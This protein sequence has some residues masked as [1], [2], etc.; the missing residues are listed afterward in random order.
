MPNQSAKFTESTGETIVIDLKDPKIAVAL[1]W[2]VP[3]LG[4]LYQGR[5]AKGLL[6]LFCI[7]GTFLLG[8]FL[9]SNQEVGWGRAVYFTWQPKRLP[10]VCQFWSGAVAVPALFQSHWASNG[11]SSEDSPLGR[12]MFPPRDSTELDDLHYSL[13][14]YF[15]LGTVYTMIAGLLNILAM[16][17]AYSGPMPIVDDKKKSKKKKKKAG[18]DDKATKSESDGD[19]QNVDKQT[20]DKVAAAEVAKE[21]KPEVPK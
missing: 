6:F 14:R 11:G 8:I 3:G 18:A 1:A 7:L 12:F 17:D 9:G 2:V 20:A 16:F 19:K 15:E 4:H 10:Y 21:A 5:Q 13:N